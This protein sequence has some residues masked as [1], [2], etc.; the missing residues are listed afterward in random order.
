MAKN[1]HIIALLTAIFV[2]TSFTACSATRLANESIVSQEITVSSFE[3][4]NISGSANVRFHHSSTHRVVVSINESAV[5]QINIRTRGN[6]LNI[7]ASG[8]NS[9]ISRFVVDVYSPRISNVTISG[10]GN[11]TAV[12]AIVTP[13]FD[14]NISG[15]GRMNG[16]VDCT[17]FN[18]R[19]SGSGSINISGSAR[20]ANIRV[21]GSGSFNGF[22]FQSQSVSAEVSGSGS[23][24]VHA[25]GS[26]NARISGSGSIVYAG[27]PNNID[28]RISGSGRIVRR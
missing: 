1:Y 3:R 2:L 14:V 8:R 17:N 21:S 19:V 27:E 5:N 15:S 13:R 6:T 7:S 23:A 26:L 12:D 16:R 24:N 22:N 28:R 25:L 9:R 4:I 10:S 11:F 20:N 18:G